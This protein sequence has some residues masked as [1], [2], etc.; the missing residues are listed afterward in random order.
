MDTRTA[1]TSRRSIR[2]YKDKKINQTI[3]NDIIDAARY[4]PS[5][6][7][8]QNW[9]VVV[10]TDEEIKEKISDCC[11]QQNWMNQAPVLLVVCNRKK[12]VEKMYGERGRDSYSIQNCAAFTQNILT[13][14]TSHGLATCWIGAF[15]EKALGR[16]LK[17]PDG[18]VPEVV[19]TIGYTNEKPKTPIRF[20]CQDMLFYETW[21]ARRQ[22]PQESFGLNR[23]PPVKTPFLKRILNKFKK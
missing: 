13:M 5:S 4:T 20:T 11:L 23:E 1:I 6:G 14:A 18:V 17:L 7:N 16:E 22:F 9:H 19:I 2:S 10:I 12:E 8:I 15:D 21:G 3:I